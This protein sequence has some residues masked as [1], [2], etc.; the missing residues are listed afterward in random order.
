MLS[1]DLPLT[2]TLTLGLR[3]MKQED[4][5]VVQEG[6]TKKPCIAFEDGF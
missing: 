5:L 4:F 2:L 1:L 6:Q 3:L